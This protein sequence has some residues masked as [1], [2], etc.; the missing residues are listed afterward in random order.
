M[1]KNDKLFYRIALTIS[2]LVFLLV[3]GLNKRIIEPPTSFPS[4]IY[5]FPMFNALINGTCAVLLLFS[6]R[7]IKQK[8][9]ELHKKLNITTFLLSAVFL[10]LYVVYHF[11]VTHTVYGGEGALKTTYIIILGLHIVLA[12][13]VLPLIL[14]AFYFGLNNKVVQHKKIVRFTYPI[15]LFVTISGV[16]VYLMIS[17]F[18][19]FP[20]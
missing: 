10:M 12:A 14:I 1:I 19:N 13:L 3:L 20:V 4:I 8:K 15:W 6:L 16:I 17:P 2:V 18:Y 9:I 7:A 11:F 5:K